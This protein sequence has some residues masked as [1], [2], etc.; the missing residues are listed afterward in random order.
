MGSDQVEGETNWK[1]VEELYHEA[2][3]RPRAER[4]QFLQSACPDNTELRR[5]VESLLASLEK[6]GALLEV[7]AMEVAARML[8]N[9]RKSSTQGPPQR[10][11]YNLDLPGATGS[12]EASKTGAIL[13]VARKI[14]RHA[15]WWMY[16]LAAAFLADGILRTYCFFLGPVGFDF[17]LRYEEELSVIAAVPAGSQTDRAGIRPGDVLLALD[18]QP[19]RHSSDWRWINSN[20][21]ANRDYVFDIEREGQ[22]FEAVYPMERVKWRRG[23]MIIWQ[24]D[25]LLLL[26][27]AFLIGFGRPYD[28][29]ARMGALSLAALSVSLA[30]FGTVPR[31]Y[32]AMWRGLPQGVDVLPWIPIVT[33][34]LAGPILLTFFLLFP[35]PLFRLRWR[36]AI[37]WLP[38]LCFVP[39]FFHSTFLIV[40]RPLQVYEF[41]LPNEV[42]PVSG[43]L[44][45]LYYLSSV[46]ALAVNYF[47][48]ADPNDRRRLRVLFVGGG[49]GVLPG[50]L[51]LLIWRYTRLSGVFDWISSGVPNLLLALIFVLL[52][53]SFAYSILRHR[54]L[55]IRLIIRQGVQYAVTRGAL[56]SLVPVLGIILV[57]DLL[58]HGD[59]PLLGIL[60]ARGWLYAALGTLA[61]GAHSQRRRWGE[62]IDRWFFRE[63]YDARRLLHAVAAEAGQARS[64]AHAA[65]GVIAQIEAALHPEFVA[66][67]QRQSGE[68][69]FQT[70]TSSPSDKAPPAILADT[71]LIYVMRVRG[72]PLEVSLGE[73]NWLQ[74]Q[75]PDEELEFVRQARIDL[76]VPVAISPEQKEA[77]IVLGAKRSEEPYTREDQKL[78]ESIAANLALPFEQEA[79]AARYTSGTFDECPQCGTCSDSGSGPCAVDG[80]QLTPVPLS[81][82]L[83]GRYQLERRRGRGGMGTVYEAKD[84]AL[85][86]RVAV[87]VI[88]D[89]FVY[90]AAAARRFEREARAG[91]AFDHP[92]VV[93]VYDYGVEAGRR[94]FLV[95]ELL[96]GATLRDQLK[97]HG[98]LTA[99]RMA[100]IF[101]PVCSAVD[102]A[103]RHQLIHRDLKPENIF[104]VRNA[105]TETETVK[106]LDFGVAKFLD[107][108]E[109]VPESQNYAVTES[110]VLVGTP[111]YM[112]PEQLL[113]ENAAI[114]WDVWALAVT[115]Y[116]TLT[117]ALPFP[118][119]NRVTWRQSV[120]AGS[121]T[122]LGEH[123]KDPPASWRE[124]FARSLV[125][126]RDR[127]PQSAAEFLQQLEHAL[128]CGAYSHDG[129]A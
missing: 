118:V 11:P 22:R 124:F 19:I 28:F 3:S 45:G 30:A 67:M 104:L 88:R 126:D 1:R 86:R 111:G 53:A 81:R 97:S 106:V 69:T 66:I 90:S 91:A 50:I 31:G 62:A 61:V 103:H 109:A 56:L 59:Q 44:L 98:R 82:T 58:V 6:D 29:L 73:S 68:T 38:A 23:V 24:I 117:G 94:A 37:I 36:W 84:K 125:V 34:Y 119:D 92:N 105:D 100:E 127:R 123:L 93:T 27:T 108:S 10:L 71:N 21:Q 57:A 48:L 2:L 77:L 7:P 54:L 33:S 18:G 80:A 129:A 87:K 85:G 102:A 16:L 128:A 17:G 95:M 63:H 12:G 122:P 35:R 78:L 76:L 64:F 49:L 15:P 5:E 113:G 121:Y 43:R 26:A 32:A 4:T 9:S 96:D 52:P 14:I 75:L 101:R 110:G 60:K 115:A 40:Y 42:R 112:S 55:D 8:A 79:L 47:R 46:V 83:A 89:D 65:P 99:A 70:L 72:G 51:R 116:E 13:T 41:I 114:S 107:A 20:L 25:G 39:A 120:L 74:R